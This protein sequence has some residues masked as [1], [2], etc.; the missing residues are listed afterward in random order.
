M[1]ERRWYRNLYEEPGVRRSV[2]V[3][4]LFGM[5]NVVLSRQNWLESIL[6]WLV[7][8]GVVPLL[9]CAV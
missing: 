3:W 4:V 5:P 1:T 6:V 7:L 9:F 2:I 8:R